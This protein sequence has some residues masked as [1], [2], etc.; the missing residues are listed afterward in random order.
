MI[1]L[2]I[3]CK[4]ENK[5]DIIYLLYYR[6]CRVKQ[7]CLI[8]DNNMHPCFYCDCSEVRK[9]HMTVCGQLRGQKLF[10]IYIWYFSYSAFFSCLV[11]VLFFFPSQSQRIRLGRLCFLLSSSSN[12]VHLHLVI[13][14][15]EW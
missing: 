1:H 6:Y 8:K 7:K 14:G 11:F 2:Y 13:V 9:H 3:H 4:H 10:Y 15:H 12:R 5:T